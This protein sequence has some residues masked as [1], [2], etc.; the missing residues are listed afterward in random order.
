MIADG[1]NSNEV[2]SI[3]RIDD[4]PAIEAF[5][6]LESHY[7]RMTRQASDNLGVSIKNDVNT[8]MASLTLSFL[9]VV[10]FSI[11]ISRTMTKPLEDALDDLTKHQKY[12]EVAREAAE[13]ANKAKSIFLANM[14]HEIRTPLNG[15]LGY[16]QILLRN[17]GLD[18]GNS[19]VWKLLAKAE[20][21]FWD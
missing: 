20:I 5:N 7:K 3:V 14:S 12:L 2:D 19:M 8:L 9:V 13:S 10:I 18:H 1:K 21:I 15:I 6:V 4:I 11:A 16:S 17:G